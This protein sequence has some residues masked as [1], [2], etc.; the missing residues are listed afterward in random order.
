MITKSD[1]YFCN[2]TKKKLEGS[3]VSKELQ[4]SR[5]KVT[6]NGKSILKTEKFEYFAMKSKY[7][8]SKKVTQTVI[9]KA[10]CAFASFMFA[11]E[12][13]TGSDRH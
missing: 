5:C 13:L 6:D 3:N 2:P 7:F 10:T 1:F 11:T 4:V 8:N 9:S 12:K